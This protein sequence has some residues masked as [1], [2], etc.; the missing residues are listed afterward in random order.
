MEKKRAVLLV[1]DTMTQSEKKLTTSRLNREGY[2]FDYA[3]VSPWTA[4]QLREAMDN[5][6]NWDALVV[7]IMMYFAALTG[8]VVFA[9]EWWTDRNLV[10]VQMLAESL[11]VEVVYHDDYKRR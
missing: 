2:S 7:S 4:E 5:A 10:R 6:E 8:V 11:G 9:G 1:P 3:E